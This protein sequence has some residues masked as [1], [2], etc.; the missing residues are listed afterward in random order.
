MLDGLLDI[1][2][3]IKIRQT[4]ITYPQRVFE[5]LFINKETY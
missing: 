1:Y 2:I 4:N 5:I 3:K